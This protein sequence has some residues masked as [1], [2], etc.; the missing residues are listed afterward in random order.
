MGSK[1]GRGRARIGTA[2]DTRRALT[3]SNQGTESNDE[4]VQAVSG[5]LLGEARGDEGLLL[6]SAR[7]PGRVRQRLVRQSGGGRQAASSNWA[8]S[9][10]TTSSFPERF[11]RSP[12]ASVWRWRWT[13]SKPPIR[14]SGTGRTWW[15]GSRTRNT[16][17]DTS[18]AW[19]PTAC[20][21]TSGCR[22][23][24]RTPSRRNTWTASE[25]ALGGPRGSR[26]SPRSWRDGSFYCGLVRLTPDVPAGIAVR[27]RFA[28]PSADGARAPGRRGRVVASGQL[29]R[30][31]PRPQAIQQRNKGVAR[32]NWTAP[33]GRLLS[34][35]L[36]VRRHTSAS[37]SSSIWDVV[38]Q[39]RRKPR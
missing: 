31:R 34:A 5:D 19:T 37:T 23:N 33:S 13:T 12:E 32:A 1:E 38:N 6:R 3:R 28:R 4:T 9:G 26:R 29:A 14:D 36:P 15:P 21:S 22:S 17:R 27:R 24:R 39:L 20:S 16:G 8:S 11:G 35:H 18:C 30:C 25:P 2:A 7:L 10:T